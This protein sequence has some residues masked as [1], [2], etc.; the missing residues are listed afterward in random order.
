MDTPEP[1]TVDDPLRNPQRTPAL[2]RHTPEGY[3]IAEDISSQY[4]YV[5]YNA[6]CPACRGLLR[7]T[8]HISRATRGLSEIRCECRICH[9]PT[10]LLFDISNTAYQRWLASLMGDLYTR[11]YA[12]PPRHPAP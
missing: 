7:V 11:H 3:I 9:H 10:I 1:R 4:D 2:F 12:G 6:A 5:K 8:A